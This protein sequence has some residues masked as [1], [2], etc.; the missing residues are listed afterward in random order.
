M[1]AEGARD[2]RY[3][4]SLTSKALFRA[5]FWF[6]DVAVRSRIIRCF[7]ELG[8]GGREPVLLR[9]E[10]GSLAVSH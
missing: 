7:T 10:P 6:V 9:G 8:D 4:G 5:V 2:L 1:V 3:E